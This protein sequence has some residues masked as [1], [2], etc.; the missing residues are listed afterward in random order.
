M[1]AVFALFA[2]LYYWAGKIT[3]AN[4]SGP[5]GYSELA[6]HLHFWTLFL[7]VNVTFFPMHFLG[8]AGMP[9]RI[10]D[11]PDAYAGWNYVAS[12]GS[13][14]SLMSVV[15]L[16]WV[17]YSMCYHNLNKPNLKNNVWQTE[18]FYSLF[19]NFIANNNIISDLSGLN[20]IELKSKTN[21]SSL[22][23]SF[24]TPADYHTA[25]QTPIMG[26]LPLAGFISWIAMSIASYLTYIG[27]GGGLGNIYTLLNY[28]LTQGLIFS[29]VTG[30]IMGLIVYI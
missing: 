6:G 23:F 19:S 5:H 11:Y 14:I 29:I 12:I 28:T 16:I 7:G 3:G 20:N 8:L 26:S 4:G 24:S 1:G 13:L 10:P 27:V 25:M 2:G 22:E 30:L 15:I 17:F 21:N 18:A 9:R